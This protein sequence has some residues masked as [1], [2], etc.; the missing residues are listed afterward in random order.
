[1]NKKGIQKGI[2][3][4]ILVLMFIL[5]IRLAM[6]FVATGEGYTVETATIGTIGGNATDDSFNVKFTSETAFVQ[7]KTTSSDYTIA[8]GYTQTLDAPG[9]E[10]TVHARE[11]NKSLSAL[12]LTDSFG[13]YNLTFIANSTNGAY[14][15]KVNG[16]WYNTI[17]GEQF[18]TLTVKVSQTI[19][20]EAGGSFKIQDATGTDIAVWDSLGNLNIKGLLTQNAEPTSDANDFVIQNSS[21]G[22]NLVVTNPEGNLLIKNSLNQNEAIPI[23]PTQKAFIIQNSSGDAISYVN[24]TGALFLMG[25]LTQDVL[26]D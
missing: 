8:L 19:D 12:W 1:M 5:A 21:G 3:I 7:N 14:I 6:S 22:L 2:A 24:H 26:F 9:M 23:S 15:I 4:I 17:P 16:T 25:T 10:K 18:S 11:A 20:L 13:D